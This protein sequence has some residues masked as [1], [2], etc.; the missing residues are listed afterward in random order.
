MEMGAKVLE[1]R[2]IQFKVELHATM[3]SSLVVSASFQSPIS[4]PHRAILLH[5]QSQNNMISMIPQPNSH[6]GLSTTSGLREDS[7]HWKE[8]V[9]VCFTILLVT[10]FSLHL[11]SVTDQCSIIYSSEPSHTGVGARLWQ[12][13]LTA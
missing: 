13:N 12:R 4:H 3:T 1:N 8:K 9:K 6:L 7:F 11:H 10:L 2:T 5:N